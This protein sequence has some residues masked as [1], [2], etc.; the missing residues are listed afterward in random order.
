MLPW[1]RAKWSGRNDIV[2]RRD[3]YI[4]SIILYIHKYRSCIII[5]IFIVCTK[6]LSVLS[7]NSVCIHEKNKTAK[8]Y[9][10]FAV[11]HNDRKQIPLIK[12]WLFHDFLPDSGKLK[13]TLTKSKIFGGNAKPQPQPFPHVAEVL[14]LWSVTR[15]PGC[16]GN[17]IIQ[18]GGTKTARLRPHPGKSKKS[19]C[20]TH[21][22]DQKQCHVHRQ[23]LQTRQILK[24]SPTV[25]LGLVSEIC[26]FKACATKNRSS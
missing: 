6:I 15:S 22:N 9:H 16:L 17:K 13:K 18:N 4:I 24:F 14:G 12:W 3:K 20:E 19:S 10:G 26:H 11:G 8:K 7:M 2:V 21:V 23:A 5:R 1:R 25:I